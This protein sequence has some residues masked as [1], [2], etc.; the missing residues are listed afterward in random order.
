M[1]VSEHWLGEVKSHLPE[2]PSD[3]R[4]RFV[5]EYGLREYDAQVL[6]LTRATGDYFEIA[7]KASGDGRTTSNWVGGT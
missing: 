5:T 3:R 4:D 2:L 7:A 1:R 6:S